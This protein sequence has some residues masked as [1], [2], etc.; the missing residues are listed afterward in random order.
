MIQSKRENVETCKFTFMPDCFLRNRNKKKI[1]CLFCV[2]PTLFCIFLNTLL[3]IFL[4]TNEFSTF[5][6]IAKCNLTFTV[7]SNY[8]NGRCD[9]D[10]I[11]FSLVVNVLFNCE[12]VTYVI[13]MSQFTFLLNALLK[14]TLIVRMVWVISDEPPLM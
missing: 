10:N 2:I 7:M 14:W 1:L 3:F 5:V 11:F 9:M 13:D 4:L 6:K 12:L 8:I